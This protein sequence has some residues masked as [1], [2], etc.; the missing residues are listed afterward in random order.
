MIITSF[1]L[2]EMKTNTFYKKY[3]YRNLKNPKYRKSFIHIAYL[4]QFT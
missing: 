3:N 2:R 4:K 1:F